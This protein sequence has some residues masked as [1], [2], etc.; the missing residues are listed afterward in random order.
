MKQ[1][2]IATIKYELTKEH[3]SDAFIESLKT[4]PRKGVQQALKSY[5]T[6]QAKVRKLQA[7]YQSMRKYELNCLQQNKQFIAGID[8]VGR[9]PL[10][11]PVVAAA[12]ILPEDFLLLGLTDS[13]K[14]NQQ[15]REYFAEIIKQKAKAIG[16]GV[17]DPES[18]D[19]YNIYEASIKAMEQAVH[20]LEQEPDHLLIDAV[21]LKNLPYPSDVIIKGDQKSIS[22]AAASVIAK[23][24]RDQ[25]MAEYHQIYPHYQ[26]NK[27]QGYGTKAHLDGIKEHGITPIHRKSFEPIKSYLKGG[28]HNGP[29]VF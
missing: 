28:N 10:A 5:H 8:E 7:E 17:I 25:L 23:V 4:D 1:L 24:Y 13:K 15:K 19:S 29:A 2:T 3:V 22:I 9:G 11:G 21:P 6:K 26:F 16:I 18:I 20:N 14:L 12:V 27:N